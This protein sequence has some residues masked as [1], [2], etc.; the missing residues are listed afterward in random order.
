MNTGTLSV[1]PPVPYAHSPAVNMPGSCYAVSILARVLLAL[2]L[3]C[4]ARNVYVMQLVRIA[5]VEPS[6]LHR[7]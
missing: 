2:A 5:A 7:L 4:A 6:I 1:L 3:E